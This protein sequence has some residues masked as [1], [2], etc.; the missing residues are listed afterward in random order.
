MKPKRLI[1]SRKGFDGGSGGCPSP[2]FCDDTMFSLPIPE[3]GDNVTFGDLRHDDVSVGDL[4]KDLTCRRAPK[5]R[6]SA[7]H[8]AHF[9]PDINF[10]AYIHR[11]RRGGWEDWR[12]AFGQSNQAQSHLR[13]EGVD[14]GDLF[15]F[16]GLYRLVEKTKDG[17]RF[18]RGAPRQHVLWGWL[19][20]GEK[21][22]LT[23]PERKNVP[24]WARHHPHMQYPAGGTNNTLYIASDVLDIGNRFKAPGAGLFP[25]FHEDLLLTNPTGTALTDWR[26]PRWFYP[27]AGKTP[28]T[29]HDPRRN[30]VNPWDH[31]GNYAYLRSMSRGQEFVL[32]LEDY[33]EAL[34]WVSSLIRD[35]GQS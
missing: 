29:Y 26:L 25:K 35:F 15:L 20:I 16:F 23:G 14:R 31:P 3:L 11:K 21:Y 4:V 10:P 5:N 13:D 19:Q 2:I 32:H 27:S 24:G 33:P 22:D 12:G 7:S 30:K 8:E 28:L 6:I 9:D 18:V 17:W 1:L 34:P